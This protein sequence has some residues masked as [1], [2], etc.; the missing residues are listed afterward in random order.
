MIENFP[1]VYFGM[2][3]GLAAGAGLVYLSKNAEP[4]IWQLRFAKEGLVVMVLTLLS[5]VRS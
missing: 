2:T 4:A 1:I 3:V 5:S